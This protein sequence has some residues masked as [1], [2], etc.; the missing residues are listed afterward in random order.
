MKEAAGIGPVL[1]LGNLNTGKST[2]FEQLTRGRS[3]EVA[4]PGGTRK[5]P[6]GVHH[7]CGSDTSR[8]WFGSSPTRGKGKHRRCPFVYDSP[9]TATLFPQNEEE[10]GAR[11]A[12]LGLCPSAILLV[13]DAKNV[14]RSLALTLHAAEFGL[15]M[16]MAVNMEDE[17]TRR[18]IGVD[19]LKL[20]RTFGIDVVKTT[21]PE[22][23]GLDELEKCLVAPRVPRR[24]V[25]FPEPI[26]SALETIESVLLPIGSKLPCS[27]HGLAL[28]LLGGD[29]V[30]ESLA[31][32]HLGEEG[33]QS[34]QEVVA[35]VYREMRRPLSLVL[36]DLIYDRADKLA[37]ETI[38][39]VSKSPTIL[40]RFGVLAEHPIWGVLVAAAVVVAMY[41]WVGALGATIVVDALNTYVFEGLL[42][43]L[44]E[45]LV[46]PIPSVFI[47]D[48]IMDSD[49]GVLPTGLFLAFGIVMPVLFFFFFAFGILQNSG[50]LPR[51]SVLLD[52][53]FRV[54]GLNGTGV[55]PLV[56][57]FSCVTMALITIRM[58]DTRKERIIASFLL[59]GLPC[60][61]LLAVMLV[62]LAEL[63]VEASLAVFGVLLVQ[64]IVGGVVAARVL[65]GLAPDFIMVIPPM[66]IP[67]IKHVFLQTL[68]QTYFFM[69]EAVPLFVVAS[70]GLF[71][72]DGVGGLDLLERVA[73]PLTEG[74]L[75]LPD[76]AVQVFIKSLVRRE[77]GATELAL[78]RSSFTNLQ[79]VV[80]LLVMSTIIPCVNAAIVLV[81]ERGLKIAA[82]ISAAVM[83][84]ALVV[85]GAV[86]HIC[87]SLGITFT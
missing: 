60:A 83:I 67:R 57:G 14:R 63:P 1:I 40:D 68:R 81:K 72:F 52:K 78:V 8:R 56:M 3:S 64:K 10:A 55:M 4:L 44:G 43:P 16:V 49:F 13:A 50:Y 31:M 25:T 29:E 46:A 32:E 76:Q 38:H 27:N 11:D 54:V 58:L 19:T 26:A 45:R 28:L 82:L 53:L 37:S 77:N 2:L 70:L 69:K 42:N 17:A 71:I 6:R 24:A 21:G 74:L 33:I 12:L 41:Y 73:R 80:T 59:L 22:G 75:Q 39:K 87:T 62:V 65:P 9:G 48:A 20:S 51:I 47:R 30:A 66:R 86:S 79:L 7:R 35:S 18:G 23:L 84:Y 85:G 36:T 15:P 34:I 61:P 5:L